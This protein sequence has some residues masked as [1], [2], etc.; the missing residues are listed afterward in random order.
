MMESFLLLLTRLGCC[1]RPVHLDRL[2]FSPSSDHRTTS[3]LQ[4]HPILSHSR[5]FVFGSAST[6]DNWVF[7]WATGS[8]ATLVRSH[9]SLRSLVPQRS[10]SLPSLRSLA[11]F[12]GSL[13][14][15]TH[16]LDSWNS[17]I[18]V[19]KSSSFSSSPSSSSLSSSAAVFHLGARYN[20]FASQSDS[21]TESTKFMTEFDFRY[22]KEME[23]WHNGT[24]L[25]EAENKGT[26]WNWI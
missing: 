24:E 8:L 10:S 23:I 25:L 17:R 7:W 11:S 2:R 9:C 3:F 1:F 6:R 5:Q 15:I 12:T 26:P 21:G 18:C 14:H 22:A 19:N 4:R 20:S 16:T 13:T